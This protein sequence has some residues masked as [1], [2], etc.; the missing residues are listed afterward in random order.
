[1]RRLVLVGVWVLSG[2]AINPSVQIGVGLATP[3]ENRNV[4]T[5]AT[6]N[7]RGTVEETQALDKSPQLLVEI[8]KTFDLAGMEVGPMVGAVIPKVRI[9]EST[10]D[11]SRKDEPF[12]VGGGVLE[13][14]TLG[15]EKRIHVGFLWEILTVDHLSN[16]W[17]QGK[18]VPMDRA[19][20]PLPPEI[21][22]GL[23][24]RGLLIVTVSGV[25]Q[26]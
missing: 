8:H 18:A 6:V 25:F 23:V 13:S 16:L 17:Q 26:K 20:L 5:A 15:G 4:P 12:G 24:Q 9:G 21:T 22:G 1:M 3:V 11:P 14:F 7:A 10:E 19:G 2:C